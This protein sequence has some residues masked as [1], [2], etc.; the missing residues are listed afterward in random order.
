VDQ[1]IVVGDRVM[2]GDQTCHARGIYKR[3]SVLDPATRTI[4]IVKGSSATILA[5][6]LC[7]AARYDATG[8]LADK[9]CESAP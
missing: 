4:L 2:C 7:N 5:W 6:E 1:A 3:T 8:V 9:G